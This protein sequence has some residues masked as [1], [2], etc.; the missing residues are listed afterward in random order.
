MLRVGTKYWPKIDMLCKENTTVGSELNCNFKIGGWGRYQK[1][2]FL[3]LSFVGFPNAFH[4]LVQTFIGSQPAFICVDNDLT[5]QV[6][7]L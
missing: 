1:L 2:L 5:S 4:G 6:M 7:P 3:A